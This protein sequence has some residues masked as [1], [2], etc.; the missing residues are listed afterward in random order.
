MNK[1]FI[2]GVAGGSGSGKTTFLKRIGLKFSTDDISIISQ[3]EYY[4]PRET[5][6]IDK[7]GVTNFGHYETYQS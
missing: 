3:D 5:Q 7:N 4:K 6:L 1:P 2:I